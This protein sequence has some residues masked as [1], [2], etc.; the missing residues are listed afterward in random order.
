MAFTLL[1]V[2][3]LTLGVMTRLWLATRQ[4]RHVV[5]HRGA[6]PEVFAHRISLTSHQRAADYTVARVRLSIIETIVDAAVLIVLTLM[7]GLQWLAEWS[8][9]LPGGDIVRQLALIAAVTVILGALGLPF[10]LWRQFRLEAKFGFNRMS[11]KLFVADT[12]K[13]IVVGTV[14]GLPLVA[15][16]LWLMQSAGTLWWVWAWVVWAIFNLAILWLFPTV[17]APLFNKFTPLADAEL[18]ARINALTQRCGFSLNGLFVMDGSK[19]SAH[20][21]A[22]FT[23]FGKAKRIVFFDTLLSRL[24]A[25]EIEAVLAHEL[26]H[27]KHRHILRRIVLSF[28]MSLG[29]LALLGWLAQR[30]WFYTGL[31]VDPNLMGPSNGLALVLFFLV[32]P[33]FTFLFTPISSWYSR[34]DEFQADSF[35]ASQTEASRLV[36]A[37]VKLYDDNAATLTPDPT[38]S[39]FYDS[40]P[41]AAIRIGHLNRSP[42]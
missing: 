26:G 33:V 18:T 1:F 23:G 10:T 41:P 16:V 9:T 14:L 7:G 42:T 40:H 30:S 37:L 39:A 22:Y 12:L 28:A 29:F 11:F 20:G 32:M 15:V 35:A 21:N 31:G 8:Y 38:H 2:T 4:I 24:N 6:V 19:R 5:R 17:I 3:V 13:G 25:D 27:F 34:R 36:S